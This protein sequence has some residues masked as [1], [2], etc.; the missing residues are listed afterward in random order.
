VTRHPA[1]RAT[2]LIV[3]VLVLVVLVLR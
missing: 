2:L 1:I 3:V